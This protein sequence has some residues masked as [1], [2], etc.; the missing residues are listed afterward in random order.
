MPFFLN[1]N[2]VYSHAVLDKEKKIPCILMD[3][4]QVVRKRI[5]IQ[6]KKT[7][8]TMANETDEKI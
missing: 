1:M 2:K 3:R 4:Q 5:I 6:Y 8:L 7:G